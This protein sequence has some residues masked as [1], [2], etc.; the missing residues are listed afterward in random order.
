MEFHG[1]KRVRLG[2]KRAKDERKKSSSPE[3]KGEERKEKN[4]LGSL[5]PLDPFKQPRSFLFLAETFD[6]D[7]F[8]TIIFLLFR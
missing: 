5:S 2:R 1:A 7:L 3:T 4:D 8:L 6:W